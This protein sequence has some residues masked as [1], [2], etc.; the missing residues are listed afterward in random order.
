MPPKKPENNLQ[1]DYRDPEL[2]RALNA[3]LASSLRK[4]ETS[5]RFMEVCG[6]HTMAIGR[7]GLRQLFPSNLELVSGP[8]CPV[9]VTATSEVDRALE[10]AN[11]SEVILATFGDMLRVPGSHQSLAQAQAEG[12]RVQ[13]VYSTFDALKLARE[14]PQREV[15]FL[16]V[17]F[18]TTSPTVAASVVAADGADT[19]NFS[20]LVGHKL[21]PPALH[22]L[23]S[24]PELGLNGFLMPGHVTAIIGAD[25]YQ[26]VPSQY[27]LACVVGGFEPADILAAVL[28]LVNQALGGDPKVEVQYQRVASFG[29][30]RN[31]QNLLN[32]VFEPSDSLWRGLGM[33]PDSGLKLRP[34]YAAYDA[35]LKF[36]LP[37]S[38]ELEV[39]DPPGCRCGQVLQGL[40]RPPECALFDSTC[41]PLTPVGPCMVS[42]EGTCAAYYKYERS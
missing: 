39:K 33:I 37:P 2:V 42:S 17:G 13:V 29:G 26:V 31:A 40:M 30:N 27:G 24:G 3:S 4:S 15:V 19:K 22:A 10:L 16:G 6:T 20:V 18:E 41:T 9:C 12:A 35:A 34:Q 32:Q 23:L 25:A 21:L 28:M 5:L 8:G 11:N 7:Y 1:S 14:N 38:D 36:G